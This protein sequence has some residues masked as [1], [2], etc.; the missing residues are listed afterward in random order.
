MVAMMVP[1]NDS[2]WFFKFM[3]DR[4]AVNAQTAAFLKFLATS[5]IP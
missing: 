2:T 3:G 1:K 5:Q 4:D